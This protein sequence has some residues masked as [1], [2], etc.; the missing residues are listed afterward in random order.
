MKEHPINILTKLSDLS[1]PGSMT[2]KQQILRDYLDVP[3][4]ERTVLYAMN[5]FKQFFTTTV[6]GLSDIKSG[7]SRTDKDA[8]SGHKDMFDKGHDRLGWKE[9]FSTMFVLL[10]KMATRALPPNSNQ[11]RDVVCEWAKKCG[12]GT[13]E[14][15]QRILRK[16]LRIGLGSKTFNKIKK[17]WVPS[18]DVQLAQPFDEKKL[19]FP[20]VVDPKFD[21]ERCLVFVTPDG[22]DYSVSYFSRNGLPFMNYG[23]FNEEIIKL[24][25]GHGPVVVDG[26]VINKLGFQSLQKVST[27]FNPSTDTSSLQF[28]VFDVLSQDSFEKQTCNMSQTERLA[29]LSVTFKGVTTNKVVLVQSK[30]ANDL[31]EATEIFD[32]WVS[33]GLEGVILKQPDGAYEF[34]RS[35]M[36]IKLKPSHSEDLKIIG[37][38]LGDSNAKWKDKCGS[39]VVERQ[40]GK[41]IVQVNVASGMTDYDHEHIHQIGDQILWK[42]PAGQMLNIK[43]KIIEV[44]YDCETEDGSLRFPRIKRRPDTLVRTDKQ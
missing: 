25:C 30:I 29:S 34:R 18:F 5:P 38:E 19:K 41:G 23:C 40:S 26:E 27:K 11:T 3:E 6:P 42:T 20:C 12:P 1:G 15:F 35:D 14:V 8:K 10:D 13:I 39:L 28:V 16:D 43:G 44:V 33:Q 22:N 7:A 24:F 4:F 36:W 17:G 9:Q 37:M 31:K 21:G 32:Y 2:T